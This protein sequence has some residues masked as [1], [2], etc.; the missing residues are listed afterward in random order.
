MATR[1]VIIALTFL[2]VIAM[3]L[4]FQ[5]KLIFHPVS[6]TNPRYS[7]YAKHQ[8]WF[9]VE[10]ARLQAWHFVF[11][12][13]PSRVILYFGGN[14]EDVTFNIPELARYG[15]SQVFLVNYRGYGQST[16]SPSQQHLYRDGLAVFDQLTEK[17]GV[18]ANEMVLFGRSLGSGV[19]TYIAAHRAAHKVIL[20]TPFD[21]IAR[22]GAGKFPF[23]PIEGFIRHPFPSVD[24]AL[25]IDTPVLMIAA[26]HD[27]VIPPAHAR[28]LFEAWR[29]PRQYALL[30]N[31]GHN[32]I[33]E[34]PRYHALIHG[35]LRQ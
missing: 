1:I 4:Y 29:G 9:D 18:P 5:E 8:V 28:S 24:F 12:D 27:V 34:H 7:H 30:D 33:S 11:N 14:A 21:S 20:V 23:L 31:V 16:G 2:G 35:F 32:D 15:A 10:N 13:Q 25:T 19:A 6:A 17:Y 22:V 26:E 3:F